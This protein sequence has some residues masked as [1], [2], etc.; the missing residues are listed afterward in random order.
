MEIVVAGKSSR[1]SDALPESNLE[2]L[3][4]FVERIVKRIVAVPRPVMTV[5]EFAQAHGLGL[6]TAYEEL[7][8]GRLKAVKVGAKTL[9]TEEAQA[10]WL[11]SLPRYKPNNELESA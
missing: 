4:P 8:T 2:Q 9:I 1:V 5:K 10:A 7:K 6:T 3:E 11:A